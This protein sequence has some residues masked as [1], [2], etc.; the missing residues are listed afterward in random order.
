LLGIRYIAEGPKQYW[1]DPALAEIQRQLDVVLSEFS[2]VV[3][4]FDDSGRNLLVFSCSAKNPGF[5]STLNLDTWKMKTVAWKRGW[6][7]DAISA[8][9]YPIALRA[10]DGLELHGFL[11]LPIG[12]KQTGLPALVLVHD[13]PIER[14]SWGYT[15]LVQFLANRGYAVLQVNYR[16]SSGYGDEFRRGGQGGAVQAMSDD[17]IDATRWTVERKFIDPHRIAI[18]GLGF[19]GYNALGAMVRAPELF[20]CGVGVDALCDWSSL[21]DQQRM[22]QYAGLYDTLSRMLGVNGDAAG[23]AKL[24]ENSP[25]TRAKDFRGPVLLV[26]SDDDRWVPISQ[27][28]A[29]KTALKRQKRTVETLKFDF[30]AHGYPGGEDGERFMERLEKFLTTNLA[31]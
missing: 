21:K 31:P 15:P 10:R 11:T 30:H 5:Y 18:M 6:V 26:H 27:M 12:P 24:R 7:K 14:D 20:R 17:I 23:E 29:M 19:G 13:G 2:N 25:A 28:D 16:G 4:N 8:E 9:Q 22:P 3:V 1:F